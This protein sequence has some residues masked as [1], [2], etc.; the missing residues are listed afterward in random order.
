[1]RGGEERDRAVAADG[2]H[3]TRRTDGRHRRQRRALEQYIGAAGAVR[4]DQHLEPDRRSEQKLL[5]AKG[6]QRRLRRQLRLQL[7]LLHH[8][9]FD[10]DQ[11]RGAADAHGGDRRID[12]HVA[13]LG[14]G[15]GDE[16]DGAGHQAEQ[17]GI[18]RPVGVVDHLVQHHL[19]VGCEAE[20]RAVDEGDAER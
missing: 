11:H 14:S 3:R 17:R 9:E 15:A 13:V 1:M 20:H 19:R 6:I 18:A 16:G 10:L 5:L 8:L 4:F 7:L 2:R 12:L